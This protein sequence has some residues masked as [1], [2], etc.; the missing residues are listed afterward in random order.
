M[1][2]PSLNLAHNVKLFRF[3]AQ[4][5]ERLL[6]RRLHPAATYDSYT[7][8][9]TIT[10]SQSLHKY[11]NSSSNN[12]NNN[13]NNNCLLQINSTVLCA[14]LFCDKSHIYCDSMYRKLKRDEGT[15]AK[16]S[17]QKFS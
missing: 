4:L 15:T 16:N 17:N 11:N 9:L 8:P 14:S 10:T 2:H 12:N 6:A 1:S 13:N 3:S 7:S 5:R